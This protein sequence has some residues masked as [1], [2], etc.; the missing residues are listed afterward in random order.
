MATT[1]PI[2]RQ[3]DKLD[4]ASPTQFRF[5]IHQ[6]PKVEFFAVSAT[7]PA[8][9]L[10][11]VV[12]P[13]PFK[14]IPMMGD[15]LTYDN[16][17]VGFIVDEYL[18]NY[19]SIHEW[20]TAIGFPKN[21]TQFSNFKTNTSNTPIDA[22]SSASTS[23]DI[24]DVKTPSS[25]NALFSDATLTILSNKNNPIVNVLFKDLYPIAMTAL[26]YNQGATDVEYITAS[27]DFAYQIYEIEAI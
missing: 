8:I 24:G 16:L 9:A 22:R 19:L 15:Q 14:S 26:D 17:S 6:L 11:D 13:T 3:P 27:V 21:R 7:I 23:S 20:M 4:Y 10:S 18:E 2:S 1:S 25:N 5:G 12:I